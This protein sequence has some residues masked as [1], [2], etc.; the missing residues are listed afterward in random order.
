MRGRCTSYKRKPENES[1]KMNIESR[2]IKR[3][4]KKQKR[5]ERKD[6]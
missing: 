2:A 6:I 1:G 3:K 5:A 4:T